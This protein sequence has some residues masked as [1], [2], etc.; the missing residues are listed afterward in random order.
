MSTSEGF[1]SLSLSSL[2]HDIGV[3]D[4]GCSDGLSAK[5]RTSHHIS[6]PARSR[7]QAGPSVARCDDEFAAHVPGEVT[8]VVEMAAG[9]ISLRWAHRLTKCVEKLSRVERCQTR[10]V[11]ALGRKSG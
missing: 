10:D 3:L 6:T 9:E 5:G 8:R 2:G 4:P 1:L 11:H 7:G